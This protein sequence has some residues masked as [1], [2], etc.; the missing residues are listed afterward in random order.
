MSNIGIQAVPCPNWVMRKPHLTRKASPMGKLT[1]AGYLDY[2][3]NNSAPK[4]ISAN[5]DDGSGYIKM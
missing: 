2:L 4:I 1:P 5:V 3:L